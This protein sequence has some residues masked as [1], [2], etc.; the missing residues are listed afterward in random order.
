MRRVLERRDEPDSQ[1]E[2][3][4]HTTRVAQASA[5]GRCRRSAFGGKPRLSGLLLKGV[6]STALSALPPSTDVSKF[7][8]NDGHIEIECIATID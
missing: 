8:R 5:D 3:R 4:R 6:G 7:I 2:R 1:S